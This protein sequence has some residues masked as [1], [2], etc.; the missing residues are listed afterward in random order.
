[1]SKITRVPLE[2]VGSRGNAGDAVI[3]DGDKLNLQS[4]AP[5]GDKFVNSIKYDAE[6]G[7]LT[8]AFSDST[9]LSATGFMVPGNIG[10]G[11]TGPTGPQGVSGKNGRDGKDGRAGEAGCAGP[12]GDIGPAG[13]AGGY[14]GIGPRGP[15]GPTGPQGAI[16]LQGPRGPDGPP[17]PTGPTGPS[18]VVGGIG[19]QGPAGLQGPQGEIGPTGPMGAT[20]PQGN[21]ITGPTGPTGATG[22]IGVD[23]P[24]G[25][26]GPIGPIGPAGVSAV[27][28]ISKWANADA[29]VGRYYTIDNDDISL[30]VAGN[31][32]NLSATQMTS[33]T[34]DFEFNGGGERVPLVYITWLKVGNAAAN[35][36]LEYTISTTDIPENSK[37]GSFTL[38]L[39]SAKSGWSFNWRV[40]LATPDDMRPEIRA[41]N[42]FIVTPAE[43][44]TGTLSYILSLDSSYDLPVSVDWETSSPDANGT[45]PTVPTASDI[46]TKWG[47]LQ[48]N[49]FFE[50]GST[51]PEGSEAASWSISGTKIT[52]SVNSSNYIAFLSEFSFS[53]F[54]IEFTVGSTALDDDQIGGVIAAV[55]EDGQNHLLVVGRNRG[56]ST[57]PTF[58][59]MYV[60]GNTVKKTLAVYDDGVRGSWGTSGGTFSKIKMTRDRNLLSV[61]ASPFGSST[62]D[63]A[64]NLNVDLSND[65]DLARFLNGAQF[66]F[67]AQSQADAYFDGVTFTFP[68]AEF[69]SE[70][71]TVVFA[72]GETSKTVPITV[73]GRA[74]NSTQRTVYL[75][76]NTPRNATIAEPGYGVGTF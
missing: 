54:T 71:G 23:G 55:R 47:R 44:A 30:E 32:T 26:T 68:A 48:G 19:P 3:Y 57:S 65:P 5:T 8:I 45:P 75:N 10:V 46:F 11:P 67:Y 52:T 43:G 1:M 56:G 38:T 15:I 14:G 39:P 31:Y 27:T 64:F 12:K 6:T 76:M 73:Y 29:N 13:P 74:D 22:P 61:T 49:T 2:L 66:G 16:G 59:I 51:I 24:R 72:P 40:L 60:I 7:T 50:A 37:A 35:P 63:N 62:Y 20:G 25:A 34:V 33:L 18:G 28:L 36:N 17:G 53:K 9:Q 70:K 42:P 41:S 69:K 58:N 4:E 21:S